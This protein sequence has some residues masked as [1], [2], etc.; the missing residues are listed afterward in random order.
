MLNSRFTLPKGA[1][2]EQ[3][4]DKILESMPKD[5]TDIVDKNKSEI[6]SPYQGAKEFCIKSTDNNCIAFASIADFHDG[7]IEWSVYQEY[8]S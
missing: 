1:S 4:W 6:I 8:L 7:E 3:I 5:L 2:D